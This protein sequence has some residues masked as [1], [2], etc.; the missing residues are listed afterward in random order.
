MA[1]EG[2]KVAKAL[3]LRCLRPFAGQLLIRAPPILASYQAHARRVNAGL[4]T[5][6]VPRCAPPKPA[7]GSWLDQAIEVFFRG[8]A[9]GDDQVM[10]DHG[11]R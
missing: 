7:T 8:G 2:T 3:L 6:L 10:T 1:R 11:G 5:G 4:Q 9:I